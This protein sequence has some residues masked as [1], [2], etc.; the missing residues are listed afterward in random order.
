MPSSTAVFTYLNSKGFGAW[1]NEKI[2]TLSTGAP[3]LQSGFVLFVSALYG[4]FRAQ[5][6][7]EHFNNSF[8]NVHFNDISFHC[9]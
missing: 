8:I 2:K 7:R 3:E 9:S 1:Q 5:K 4:L 6:Q